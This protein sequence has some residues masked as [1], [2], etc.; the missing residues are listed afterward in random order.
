MMNPSEIQL[1]KVQLR[2][3]N[4]PLENIPAHVRAAC[5]P[6]LANLVPGARI[7][8][9]VGSRGISNIAL[10]ARSVVEA[11]RAAGGD[12]FIIPAMGSHGGATAEGQARVLADYGATEEYLGAP[13]CS[14]M[15]V[16]PL[17]RTDGDMDIPVYMDKLAA[18]SDGVI[19]INRVKPHTDF[20]GPHESGIVKMLTIGLGKQAQAAAVHRYGAAGL[21]D[22][23]PRVTEKVIASGKILGALAILEDGYDQTSD[24]AF[25]SGMEIFDLDARFLERSR[26]MMAR[27]PFD[28][29]DAL[30]VDC[31]GKNFSGTGMD[32]NVIGRL[33]IRG[34]QDGAPTCA[35]V[36]VLDLS[37]ES[38]GNALGVGLADVTTERLRAK[39]DWAATNANVMTSGFLERG[40]LPMV[41]PDD[42]RAVA[43]AASTC[44][45]RTPENIRLVRIRDTL[46]LDEI[47]ISR[48][49]AE[50]I[51]ANPRCRMLGDFQPMR[52]DTDGA[53]VAF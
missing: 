37:P 52:F 45:G 3:E 22:G 30:V 49:L 19:A 16:V 23:I 29:L 10:I 9:A 20:H 53:L 5:Q 2:H 48:A 1:C 41:M 6:A 38:H 47:Y 32:T 14:C 44:C 33:C 43:L 12:P 36:V 24:V 26:R 25:A 21:R 42:H 8:I 11:V 27:L 34:Q 50:E 40:F 39:I 31:M 35:R 15:E 7:A 51:Q 46:H 18:Q 28:R 17:G 4:R 13:V